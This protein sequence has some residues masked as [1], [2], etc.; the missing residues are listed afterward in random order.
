MV[1]AQLTPVGVGI[2]NV[3]IATDF[4]TYSNTALKFGLQLARSYKATAHVVFVVPADEF[5]IAG[6]EAYVAAKDAATRD[7]DELKAELQSKHSY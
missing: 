1:T 3:L 2:H 7:L 5:L 4:S 6:P